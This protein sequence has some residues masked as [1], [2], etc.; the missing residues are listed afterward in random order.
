VY[1]GYYILLFH[2][3]VIEV[4]AQCSNYFKLPKQKGGFITKVLCG[5]PALRKQVLNATWTKCNV[6]EQDICL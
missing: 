4:L 6:S 5:F 1:K 3:I 2:L